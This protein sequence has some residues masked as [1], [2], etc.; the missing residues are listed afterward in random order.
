MT[1]QTIY[2]HRHITHK[3]L[4]FFYIKWQS[5]YA[6]EHAIAVVKIEW[7]AIYAWHLEI[8]WRTITPN[9]RQIIVLCFMPSERER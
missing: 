5:I 2:F 6:V 4:P 7:S 8:R 9:A 3:L 1:Q